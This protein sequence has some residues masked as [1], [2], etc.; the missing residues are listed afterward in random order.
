MAYIDFETTAPTD[1][2][3]DP[4]CSSVHAVSYVIVFAFHP[5]LLQ[6]KRVIIECSFGH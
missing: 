1:T 3:L 5:D 4:E 6:I 2:C